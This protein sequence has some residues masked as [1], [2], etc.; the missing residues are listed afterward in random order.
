MQKFLRTVEGFNP[1]PAE[2]VLPGSIATLDKT[3]G[4][5][6]PSRPPLLGQR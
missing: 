5:T 3:P 1:S 2:N 6:R 4:R